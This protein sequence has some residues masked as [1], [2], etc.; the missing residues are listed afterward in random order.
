MVLTNRARTSASAGGEG[1]SPAS[2]WFR[3]TLVLALALALVLTAPTGAAAQDLGLPV[4]ARP[5][6]PA[7]ED[8]DGHPVNLGAVIGTKPVLLEFWAT[9]CSVCAELEP[10]MRRVHEQYGD[11]VEVVVVAV[12][13]N[14]NPRTI[15]RHL[16]RSPMAG[17]L[18]FDRRGALTRA[19]M[20]PA[21]S[22]VV[23]LD[24]SGKVAY[25]GQGSDQDLTAAVARVLAAY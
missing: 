24:A 25:T 20:A 14:Q 11:D 1:F 8:L 16:A 9:W 15:R 10:E 21:T 22:Y 13:V 18:V 23:I 2:R 5:D 6:M 7:F 19:F 17:T 3:S 12:G 4:G